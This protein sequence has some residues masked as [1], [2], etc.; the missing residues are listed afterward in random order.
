MSTGIDKMLAMIAVI[1]MTYFF[2]TKVLN[3]G[4][5]HVSLVNALPLVSTAGHAA[6]FNVCGLAVV[7]IT[8]WGVLKVCNRE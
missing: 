8:V 6:F 1:E 5:P 3:A 7:A 4:G 2:I